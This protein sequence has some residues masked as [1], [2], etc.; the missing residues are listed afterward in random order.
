MS[1][2]A[3]QIISNLDG[4]FN[5]LGMWEAP[6]HDVIMA[7]GGL[8][9]DNVFKLQLRMLVKAWLVIYVCPS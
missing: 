5:H 1:K 4:L 8:D 6:C 3:S 2:M 7:E 9:R